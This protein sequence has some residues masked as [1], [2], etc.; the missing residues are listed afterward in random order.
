[1]VYGTNHIMSVLVCLLFLCGATNDSYFCV[2]V[3]V[4]C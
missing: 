2:V 4:F 3:D 1:M